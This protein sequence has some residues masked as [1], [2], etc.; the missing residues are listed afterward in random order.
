MKSSTCLYPVPAKT[1]KPAFLGNTTKSP[2]PPLF[3]LDGAPTLPVLAAKGD[4]VYAADQVAFR[5]ERYAL[6]AVVRGVL[7]NSRTANCCRSLS[8][9]A[10][11][12]PVVFSPTRKRAAF[13][14][15]QLCA[16]VWAC[17]VCSVKI[18][19]Q[20]RTD[21]VAVVAAHRA[22]GGTVL[23]ITRTFPHSSRDRIET[24]TANL[25]KAEALY[26]SG[27]AWIR[28]KNKF[29]ISGS[30]RSVEVTYGTNG[31]HPHIH[32]LVFIEAGQADP[33]ENDS[34]KLALF[35][36]WFSACDRAGLGTPTLAHGIDV[37][38]GTYA[39]KYASKWGIE[40][41]LTKWHVKQGKGTSLTPFDLLRIALHSPNARAVSA[42][43][44]LFREYAEAFHGKRQLV[45][46][47]GLVKKYLPEAAATDEAVAGK[48]DD[49]ALLLGI[50]SL[51]GW[52]QVLRVDARAA[53]LEHA[54]SGEWGP[55]V[56]FLNSIKG[57]LALTEMTLP[58][59]S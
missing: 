29:R 38:D 19:E 27:P 10:V 4:I 36:R 3:D 21:L 25:K 6:Q 59:H 12:V 9:G 24:L 11:C 52:K 30:V 55:V 17:P 26:K 7:P 20:R 49:D 18:S 14:N 8:Y 23:L 5:A 13:R 2:S 33:L 34:L 56:A 50:L 41:E 28:V 42:A 58:P 32:E 39:A 31:W 22:T 51:A 46:S 53:L 54:S 15:L 43:R 40:S 16:S 57:P 35:D 48:A 37:R 45:Y 1:A 44:A 47:P